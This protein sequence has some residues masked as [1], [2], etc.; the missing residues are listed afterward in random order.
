[1]LAGLTK[2]P[3]G[4][5]GWPVAE[6]RYVTTDNRFAWMTGDPEANRFLHR[7]SSEKRLV[8]RLLLIGPK[9]ASGK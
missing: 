9:R 1:V 6:L 2:V 8:Y 5:D 3:M 4:I 7:I